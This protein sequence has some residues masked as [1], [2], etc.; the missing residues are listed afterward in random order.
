M[1]AKLAR[2]PI[3]I[4]EQAMWFP[5][6]ITD[7]ILIK[8][9]KQFSERLN[10][11]VFLLSGSWL[12]CFKFLV[13]HFYVNTVYMHVLEVF[14]QKFTSSAMISNNYIM[15]TCAKLTLYCD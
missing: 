6:S 1:K 9:T 14:L 3:F 13:L 5:T 11:E 15:C 2:R 12:S 8:K 10:C 4:K 7:A